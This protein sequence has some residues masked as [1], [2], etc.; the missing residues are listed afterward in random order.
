MVTGSAQM[1]EDDGQQFDHTEQRRFEADHGIAQP[2]LGTKLERMARVLNTHR[3]LVRI[4][5]ELTELTAQRDQ[6]KSEFY[7]LCEEKRP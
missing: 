2:L 1:D 7:A 4:E 5:A 3:R 6:V